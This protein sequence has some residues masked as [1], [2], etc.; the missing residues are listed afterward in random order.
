MDLKSRQASKSGNN[1][2]QRQVEGEKGSPAGRRN[3][4]RRSYSRRRPEVKDRVRLLQ[5]TKSKP[6]LR[7]TRAKIQ[8]MEANNVILA[9]DVNAWSHWWSSRAEDP[10][11]AA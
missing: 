6:Y 5:G 8:S 2:I 10:R 11:G 9:G 4:S 3:R 7:R 1:S